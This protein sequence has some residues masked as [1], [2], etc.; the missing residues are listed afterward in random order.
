[1]LEVLVLGWSDQSATPARESKTHT[2]QGAF[3][4]LAPAPFLA[5]LFFE[6]AVERTT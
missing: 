4:W 1:M 3:L 6:T 5:L 2:Q